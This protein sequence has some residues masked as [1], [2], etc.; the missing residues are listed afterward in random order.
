MRATA[1]GEGGSPPS[2]AALALARE[3]FKN[4]PRTSQAA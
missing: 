1:V 4:Q 3:V 2:P